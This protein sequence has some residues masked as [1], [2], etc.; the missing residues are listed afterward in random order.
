MR[1]YFLF[2][3]KVFHYHSIDF[4]FRVSPIPFF[5]CLSVRLFSDTR[6]DY[7]VIMSFF[8]CDKVNSLELG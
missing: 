4:Y 5:I 8:F 7:Y 3:K 2:G 6:G 1:C